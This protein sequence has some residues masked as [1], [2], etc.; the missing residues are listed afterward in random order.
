MNDDKCY[1]VISSIYG[2]Q[3]IWCSGLFRGVKVPF[4]SEEKLSLKRKKLTAR[5]RELA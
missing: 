5:G 4:G 3:S 2:Q 1:S